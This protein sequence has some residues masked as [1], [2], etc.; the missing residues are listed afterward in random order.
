MFAG[1][2]DEDLRS[3]ILCKSNRQL[4]QMQRI[5]VQLKC[6]TP[7]MCCIHGEKKEWD[8]AARNLE[9]RLMHSLELA[10][11]R[12]KNMVVPATLGHC[13]AQRGCFAFASQDKILA[14]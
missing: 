2:Q 3:L 4:W 6:Q 13:Q 12:C 8:A 1:S 9:E 7:V 14:V 10:G 11:Q 5:S